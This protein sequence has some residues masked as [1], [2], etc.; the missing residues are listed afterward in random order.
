MLD[1]L[2]QPTA[3]EKKRQRVAAIAAYRQACLS[4]VSLLLTDDCNEIRSA[5]DQMLGKYWAGVRD[6]LMEK[7]QFTDEELA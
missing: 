4:V 6:E 1:P 2:A 3:Y 5:Y 7:Y